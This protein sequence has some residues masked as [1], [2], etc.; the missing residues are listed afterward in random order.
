MAGGARHS[1]IDDALGHGIVCLGRAHHNRRT[2]DRLQEGRRILTVPA[3][4][5]AFEV[6]EFQNFFLADQRFLVVVVPAKKLDVG[7]LRSEEHTSELQSLMRLSSA[8]FYL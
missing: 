2:A 5:G 8:V 1:A 3:Q 4:L 7:L 6:L